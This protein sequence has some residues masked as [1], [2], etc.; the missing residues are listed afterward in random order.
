MHDG[1]RQTQGNAEKFTLTVR[2]FADRMQVSMPTA[3]AMTEQ[4]GFPL[5]R[6]GTKKLI[7]LAALDEWI[8]Q[9]TSGARG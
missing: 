8:K 1:C 6:V 5:L 3:Y 7:P 9:Q 2:Q 4:K